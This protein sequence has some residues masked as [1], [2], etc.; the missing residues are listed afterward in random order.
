MNF[1]YV[2]GC[3]VVRNLGSDMNAVLSTTEGIDVVVTTVPIT[4]GVPLANRNGDLVL[5]RESD[6]ALSQNVS[7]CQQSAISRIR[8]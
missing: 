7:A 8:S 5:V 3:T 1:F 4:A 6:F 2:T